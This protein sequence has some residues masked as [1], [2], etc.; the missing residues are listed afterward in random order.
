MKVTRVLFSKEVS[1]G[2]SREVSQEDPSRRFGGKLNQV[3]WKSI[4][5][6]KIPIPAIW[7]GNKIEGLENGFLTGPPP[8]F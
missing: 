7:C 2:V 8:T 6:E 4:S 1:N 3:G 5:G